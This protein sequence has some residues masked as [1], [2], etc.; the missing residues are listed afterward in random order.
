M[1]IEAIGQKTIWTNWETYGA[2][3]WNMWFMA[4]YGAWMYCGFSKNNVS[5][6][7]KVYIGTDLL[8]YEITDWEFDASVLNTPNIKFPSEPYEGY[9]DGSMNMGCIREGT[10]NY[11]YVIGHYT[12]H[13]STSP[14]IRRF[15]VD[16]GFTEE[17]LG[18]QPRDDVSVLLDIN[19]ICGLEV[20]SGTSVFIAVNNQGSS[21]YAIHQYTY[22]GSWDGGEHD[23][24]ATLDLTPYIADNTQSRIRGLSMS[25]DGNLLV[26]CNTGETATS[27]ITL[28]FNS[29]T[30]AYMGRT[31]WLDPN[32]AYDA[33]S[34]SIWANIVVSGEVFLY[35]RGL[36]STNFSERITHIFYD[37]STAIPSEGNSNFIINNNLTSFGSDEAITL[38]YVAKDGFNNKVVAVNCKFIIDDVTQGDST[39][40][41]TTIGGI[42]ESS[43]NSFFD[44]D[45][46]PLSVHA[47]D[48]TNSNGEALA[49]YKPMRSGTGTFIDTINVLCPSDN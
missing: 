37:N 20:V 27:T 12:P 40:W 11:L 17:I 15:K 16:E 34:T 6:F 22:A 47:I 13:P 18:L 24:D 28:K 43:G 49:Y 14:I 38:K 41:D 8:D 5:E 10:T 31:P 2:S 29:S 30:L 36:D 45:G 26:F 19:T 35:F 46:V 25:S 42:Q 39:T 7:K 48:A 4:P 33:I 3:S 9:P 44:A 23:A 1:G 32:S 21:S